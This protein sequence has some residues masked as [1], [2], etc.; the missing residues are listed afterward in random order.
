[1]QAVD[2]V[3]SVVEHLRMSCTE[4]MLLSATCGGEV[5]GDKGVVEDWGANGSE[6]P[7]NE[8]ESKMCKQMRAAGIT[9]PECAKHQQ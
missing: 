6:G 7:D 8:T 1:M 2:W 4:A 3:Q 9:P 5:P